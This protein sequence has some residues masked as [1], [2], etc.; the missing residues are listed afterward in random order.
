MARLINLASGNMI[1]ELVSPIRWL[2]NHDREVVRFEVKALDDGG[3]Y[4]YAYLDNNT[5]L[6]MTWASYT[7][8]MNAMLNSRAWRNHFSG[9]EI[10]KR[11]SNAVKTIP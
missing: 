8:M 1:K 6:Q 2:F 5:M 10:K 11:G 4:L 3:S 7:V 9:T